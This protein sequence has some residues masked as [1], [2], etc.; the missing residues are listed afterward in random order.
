MEESAFDAAYALLVDELDL[1]AEVAEPE[2]NSL[3]DAW[4]DVSEEALA[5]LE[6]VEEQP[7]G[8]AGLWAALG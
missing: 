5:A 8:L 4:F 1:D 3:D 7:R 2:T 6:S